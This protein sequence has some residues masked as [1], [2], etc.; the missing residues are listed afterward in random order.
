VDPFTPFE[1]EAAAGRA[2][3]SVL[4]IWGWFQHR[5]GLFSRFANIWA[6]LLLWAS[7]PLVILGVYQLFRHNS[8]IW[9]LLVGVFASV[10]TP[11]CSLLVTIAYIRRRAKWT[12]P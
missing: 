6:V 11:L 9:L 12:S 3:E 1:V 8:S 2:S 4:T 7:S 10:L 5:A